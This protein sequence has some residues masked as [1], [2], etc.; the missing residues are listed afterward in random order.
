MSTYT[1]KLFGGFDTEKTNSRGYISLSYN[2]V[3]V[4]ISLTG[5]D[6]NKAKIAKCIEL[7]DCYAEIHEIAKKAIVENYASSEVIRY[8]FKFHFETLEKEILVQ[9][10]GSP[11]Y[12]AFSI[13]KASEQLEYPNLA[14]IQEFDEICFSVKYRMSNDYSQ[15]ILCVKMDENLNVLDFDREA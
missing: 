13:E 15:E 6:D 10:F 3:P 2:D 11:D 5:V 7:I 12:S 8:Y 4:Y 9:L 1:T 14:F